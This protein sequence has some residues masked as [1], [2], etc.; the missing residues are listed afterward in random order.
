MQHDI[1][2]DDEEEA[3][4]QKWAHVKDLIDSGELARL[5]RSRQMTEKY[6]EHKRK[7]AGLDI[8]QYVLQK[9]GW[10]PDKSQHEDVPSKAFS[11][12]TLYA[13]RANDFPYSFEP[14]VVHLVLWSKIAL[15]VHSPDKTVRNAARERMNAFLQAQPFLRPLVSL[16][17]VAWFVN[18]PELQSVARIFHAHVLLYFPRNLYSA[19]QMQVAVDDILSHGFE[20]L[21]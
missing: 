8:N 13:V 5:K 4:E 19:E 17:H 21:V 18:Y 10:S 11:A 9:L 20:P 2:G 1:V 7:T 16:G 3:Q 14:G 12:R 6:H 15:P